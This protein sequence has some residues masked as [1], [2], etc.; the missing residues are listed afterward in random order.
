M[1]TPKLAFNYIKVWGSPWHGLVKD[2]VLSLPNNNQMQYPQ[3]GNGDT[4]LVSF[5]STPSVQ[6]SAEQASFDSEQGKQ[7]LNYAIIAGENQLHGKSIPSNWLHQDSEGGVWSVEVV[8]SSGSVSAIQVSIKEFGRIGLDLIPRPEHISEISLGFDVGEIV[9]L[10]VRKDGRQAVFLSLSDGR[11][12][13]TVNINNLTPSASVVR[14]VLDTFKTEGDNTNVVVEDP[15][16]SYFVYFD[17]KSLP[18]GGKSGLVTLDEPAG[19]YTS[20]IGPIQWRPSRVETDSEWQIRT[21]TTHAFYDD[22][23]ELKFVDIKMTRQITYEETYTEEVVKEGEAFLDFCSTETTGSA[24]GS[25]I[26]TLTRNISTQTLHEYSLEILINDSLASKYTVT[27]SQISSV[28]FMQNDVYPPAYCNVSSEDYP[29][30][31]VAL[32]GDG[33]ISFVRI[34]T[35]ESSDY[36]GPVE[37]KLNDEPLEAEHPLDSEY[38]YGFAAFSI[39][40]DEEDLPTL[41]YSQKSNKLVTTEIE[42]KYQ[43]GYLLGPH[44]APDAINDDE[45]FTL[46]PGSVYATYNPATFQ[47]IR[48]QDSP[49]AFV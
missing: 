8:A 35:I 3:P 11:Q 20:E 22:S 2:G 45:F 37:W 44:I 33:S 32:L 21:I 46:T 10:D 31:A 38:Y 36:T 18:G 26:T 30:G 40:S 23:G 41:K 24:S 4:I 28:D 42:Y 12:F 39:A 27:G 5:S 48:D 1:T 9:L 49:V 29:P 25:V 7:W 19:A 13:F 34:R 43:P 47:I 17:I 6:R 14:G 16:S 15:Y